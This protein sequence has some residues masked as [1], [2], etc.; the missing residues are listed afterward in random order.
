MG[1][2][3]EEVGEEGEEEGLVLWMHGCILL[4]LT[5]K[6]EH[7]CLRAYDEVN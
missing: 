2:E 1:E 3:G 4:S 7:V 6:G 5:F